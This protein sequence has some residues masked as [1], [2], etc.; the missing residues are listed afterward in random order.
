MTVKVSVANEN[1]LKQAIKCSKYALLFG[2]AIVTLLIITRHGRGQRPSTSNAHLCIII[3]RHFLV[4]RGLR[5]S[6]KQYIPMH[7]AVI[8]I[9]CSRIA[10]GI[11]HAEAH[12]K[13][14]LDLDAAFAVSS[15]PPHRKHQPSYRDLPLASTSKPPHHRRD[16]CFC[17]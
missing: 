17:C 6:S 1:I 12:L 16:Q 3:L 8:C 9:A 15:R 13:P 5:L 11:P 14:H 10:R 4:L 7:A 2:Q